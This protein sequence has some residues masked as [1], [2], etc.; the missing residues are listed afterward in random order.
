MATSTKTTK[1][2][3]GD[4]ESPS[5]SGRYRLYAAALAVALLVFGFTTYLALR[6]SPLGWEVSMLA[7]INGWSEGWYRFFTIATFFGSTWMALVVVAGTFLA[8]LYRM[9]WCLALT[10]IGAYGVAFL[11]KHFIERERP[12]EILTTIH[13]RVA[14]TG[15]G[16]PSGH[17]T[18]STVIAL[19]VWPYLPKRWRYVLVP[20]FIGLV[21]LSRLYL[22]VHFPLDIIG[23][24]AIGV[25]A[26]SFLHILPPAWR[27]FLRIQ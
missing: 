7:A 1:L 4:Q 20:V 17:A 10:I 24:I 19:T 18:L 23:G 13:A 22:G 26:V 3:P 14:E 27:S 15:M 12:F 6:G 25:G 5:Y 16:F 9:A 2:S 21:C 11:A 8:R